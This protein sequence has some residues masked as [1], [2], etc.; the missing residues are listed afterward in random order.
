[1][2][3]WGVNFITFHFPLLRSKNLF[4]RVCMSSAPR[5]KQILLHCRREL[6]QKKVHFLRLFSAAV[7]NY[8]RLICSSNTRPCVTSVV[9]NTTQQ[10]ERQGRDRRFVLFSL[11]S[12]RLHYHPIRTSNSTEKNQQIYISNSKEIQH[13]FGGKF[14]L[15]GIFLAGI[16]FH[17]FLLWILHFFS[18]TP[19]KNNQLSNGGVNDNGGGSVKATAATPVITNVNAAAHRLTM[20]A[21]AEEQ[22]ASWYSRHR[23][24]GVGGGG[25]GMPDDN[26]LTTATAAMLNM[27]GGEEHAG[28][29]GLLYD[30]YNGRSQFDKGAS[31]KV[32]GDF[33][34]G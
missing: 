19:K 1:M 18:S 34:H 9:I 28:T 30:Y 31:G 8:T 6:K 5:R 4:F 27:N 7:Q 11:S 33:F 29:M 20:L 13:F 25:G 2:L 16:F 26:P 32:F 15:A 17:S 21:A 23:M 12:S 24:L 14:F 10:N 3:Q 22:E